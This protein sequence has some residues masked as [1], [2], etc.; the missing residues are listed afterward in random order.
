MDRESEFELV[1]RMAA[2]DTSAFDV[3]YD[4]YRARLYSFLVRLSRRRDLAEDLLEETWL[5]LVA[6]AG[7]FKESTRGP[8]LYTVARNLYFSYCR[9]RRIEDEREAG[10]ASGVVAQPFAAALAIRR[11][12]RE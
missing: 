9:S 3:I 1:E 2:G 8:W 7:R 12:S 10:L 6:H 11:G 4:Q 5:R